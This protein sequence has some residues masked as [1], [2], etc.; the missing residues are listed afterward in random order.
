MVGHCG[1]RRRF[2]DWRR[3]KLARRLIGV[4]LA[5]AAGTLEAR[6]EQPPLHVRIEWG[7]S[8]ARRWRGSL[9]V[10]EGSVSTP[11]PLGIEADEPGSMWEADGRIV[12]ES[13]SPRLYDGLDASVVAPASAR[14]RLELFAADQP[15]PGRVVEIP[16][17]Q[18]LAEYYN[19]QLDE[20]GNRVLARRKPG[21][22][23]QVRFARP[24]LVFAPGE[25][26]ACE[27][28]PRLIDVPAGTRLRLHARL[29]SRQA[30]IAWSHEQ[31]LNVDAQGSV[32]DA[33][34]IS[35]N[36][37]PQE[38]VYDLVLTVARRG[39]QE[40][41][42]L[43]PIFDERHVQ[44][45]CI[46]RERPPDPAVVPAPELLLEI[47]PASPTWPERLTNLSLV[48]G[49]RRGPLGSGDAVP[50]QHSL[51]PLIQLNP[52]PREADTSWEA[53]PLSVSRVGQPHTLEVE[54]PSDVPQSLGVSILEPNAAGAVLPIGL[55]SGVYLSDLAAQG[56]PRLEKH[57]LLFWPRTSA[58]LLLLTNRRATAKAVYGKVRVLGPRAA[59]FGLARQSADSRLARA[60]DPAQVPAGRLIA[61]YFDRPL[62]P[63][64]FSANQAFDAWSA[65]SGRVLD[66]WETFYEGATRLVE[67]LN[68]VG[69]N[70]LL[71]S[72]LAD[73]STI[74]PSRLL[75][76]TPRY[77]DGMFF[78]TG[79]DPERKDVL[80]LVFRLFDRES[81]QLVPAL[82]FS[83]PLP[84]L[85]ALRRKGGT[86]AEG[87][88]LVNAAGATW[89]SQ[90]EPRQGMAP[91]YNPLDPRVQAAMLAVVD[92]VVERYAGHPSFAGLA[93]QL[94]ADGYAQ[95][96]GPEWGADA[97]TLTRFA[98][99]MQ[100]DEAQD[101][102]G[103]RALG[104]AI[105]GKY[106]SQWL[107]WRA[108]QL[109]RFYDRIQRRLG[110]ARP[111]ARLYLAG[112][113]AL[114]RPELLA[115]LHPTLP[116]S[117]SP[118]D[119]LRWVGLEAELYHDRSQI[120]LLRP[121]RLAP[122]GT[123][124]SRAVSV[125]LNHAPDFDRAFEHR[126]AAGNIFFHEPQ[127]ARL[128]S[129]DAKSPFRVTYTRLVTE[130][131][132][133]G[134]ENRRRFVHALATL[135]SQLLFDGGWLLPLGEEDGL[136]SFIEAYRRLP[137]AR[138]TTVADVPQPVTIRSH[139]EGNRTYV[140]L[141]NDSPWRV[142]TSLSVAAPDSCKIQRLGG[143]AIAP[144]TGEAPHRAWKVE[145]GPYDLVAAAFSSP[146]VGLSGVRTEVDP[147]GVDQLDARVRELWSR[148][149]TLKNPP[150]LEGLV[151]PGFELAADGSGQFPGWQ[152]SR[153]P[154]ALARLDAG[155]PHAG[156][157]AVRLVAGEA[158]ADLMSE[159]LVVPSTGRLSISVW[160]RVAKADQQPELRLGVQSAGS[161]QPFARFASLGSTG[162][163]RR[164]SSEWTRYV[165]HV[166]DLPPEGVHEL[167]IRFN[168]SSPG[169]VWIDDVQA[170]ALD[171]SE[172]ERLELSKIITLAEYKRKSGDYGDCFRLLDGYWPRFLLA[173]VPAAH[174][175]L[176]ERPRRGAPA[177]EE[178]KPSGVLDRFRRALPDFWR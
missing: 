172:A 164:L 44:L 58:P 23:I 155:Q 90:H 142:T 72:V 136:R 110:A 161:S 36:L 56:K 85:E 24:S 92:E 106:Q 133:A 115:R 15:G 91:Y 47:D 145:L 57:R 137:A 121:E 33:A 147:A 12:I 118:E 11:R 16:L 4:L 126:S 160:L 135:D 168:L 81:L 97:A 6:G 63:E 66:D 22:K 113:D 149:A 28:Q 94:S 45:V 159:P 162:G 69:F 8:S 82:H 30:R 138:F 117:T 60:I 40:R 29:V 79:Q 65:P 169:E 83:A 2:A 158:G 43:R 71:L 21:D 59:T 150:S 64:N 128:A 9:S 84:Q 108:R 78:S 127:E 143:N 163:G 7:G 53:Y 98:Q 20:R 125:E 103:R 109:A 119:I 151:N 73:G 120:V 102:A 37:P 123:L 122:P 114:E 177:A 34:R 46:A 76:P 105:M 165:L 170:V 25:T 32:A 41:L 26:F 144:L 31:E 39:L 19:V 139:V 35:L 112:A 13:R 107:T 27:V 130:P 99:D 173:N 154:E 171:F 167:A 89:T 17:A 141:V 132:P 51:A 153:Q 48:P 49:W 54:F 52:S 175:S 88:E 5:L 75:E 14:L 157:Q 77:D 166:G 1:S 101:K 174:D 152:A 146:G 116:R 87:I 100:L 93:L 80:E 70:G 68:H 140:Y 124:A 178:P 86:D 18:A 111:E 62:F 131:S 96:P 156:G 148:A 10:D 55:D 104:Q 50:W 42:G 3:A 74:Y 176:A 95:F 67:Y 61:G 129:F 38:G 134:A